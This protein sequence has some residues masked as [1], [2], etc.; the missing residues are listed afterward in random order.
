M[1]TFQIFTAP[2]R[3]LAIYSRA[4]HD[5]PLRPTATL[6]TPTT[7]C[8][9][10]RLPAE[11]FPQLPTTF[12]RLPAASHHPPTTPAWA[13]TTCHFP[14]RLLSHDYPLRPTATLL[15]PTTTCCLPRL[16]AEPFPQLPTT[17][18]RLPAASHDPPTT[19]AWATTTCHF[20]QRLLSHDTCCPTKKWQWLGEKMI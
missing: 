2:C 1:L 3:V 9:L 11:P 14:Q 18:P 5:Y 7:T 16:P 15:T 4:S 20:P 13:T 10:P 12:P 8:C 6:L 17:F 19:P